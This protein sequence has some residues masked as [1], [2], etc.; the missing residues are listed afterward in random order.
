M[1]SGPSLFCQNIILI[2][3]IKLRLWYIA[4]VLIIK[5]LKW[6]NLSLKVFVLLLIGVHETI[7][8]F[9]VVDTEGGVHYGV[10]P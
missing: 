2:T 6:L 8:Y 1:G 4:K 9:P 7:D 5:C 3:V 10:I